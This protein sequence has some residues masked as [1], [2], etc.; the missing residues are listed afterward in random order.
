MLLVATADP[1]PKVWNLMFFPRPQ[2]S[3]FAKINPEAYAVEAL[4]AVLFKG[5]GMGSILADILFLLVFTAVMMT[6]AV[7]FKRTL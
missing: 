1:H 5:V 7:T 4:K 3:L 6:A 2:G